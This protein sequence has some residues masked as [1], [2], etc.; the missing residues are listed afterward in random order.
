VTGPVAALPKILIVTGTDTGVGKTI[1]TA[2]LAAVLGAQASPPTRRVAVY[3]P[4]QTGVLPGEAGDSDVVRA[5][6]GV[7]SASDGVRLPE[8]MAPV[9]AAD[10]AGV[11]LPDLDRHLARVRQLAREHDHV[12][13][14]GAGGVLV[15]LDRAGHTLADLAAAVGP[16]TAVVVVCRSGLGALNHAELTLEAL[17]RRQI[18]IAGLVIGSWPARPDDVDLSNRDYLAAMDVPLIGRIPEG[19]GRLSLAEFRVRA[20]SWFESDLLE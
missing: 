19:A 6:T 20:P 1:T 8:P 10:R 9:A 14:E 15:R 12:L 17:R 7:R 4:T 2:A 11:A 16:D 13:V 3:K 18:R 5:L